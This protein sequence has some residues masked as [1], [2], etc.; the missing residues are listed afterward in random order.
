MA[1][2]DSRIGDI[3]PDWRQMA[4]HESSPGGPASAKLANECVRCLQTHWFPDVPPGSVKN[5]YRSEDLEHQS[6]PDASFD[7]VITQDVFEHV[8][9]PA[10]AFTEVARTLKHGGAHVF[11]VP[12]YH[13]KQTFVRAQRASD[14]TVHH[15]AEPDYHGNP[16]DSN[17][18]LVVTEWGMDL[19]DFVYLC[20]GL[21]TTVVQIHDRR[22]GIAG[23][24]IEVFVSQK[25]NLEVPVTHIPS[26]HSRALRPP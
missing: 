22:Q 21:T 2:P 16:I 1:H 3:F 11:T 17:G 6:F 15:L 23:K 7:L 14:G 20:S 9:D 26:M 12:W 10:S 25:P 19:C 18:S 5:G 8:L 24:F 13:W 4:I